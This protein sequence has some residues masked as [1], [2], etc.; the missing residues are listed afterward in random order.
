MDDD[1][2]EEWYLRQEWCLDLLEK[3]DTKEEEEE[4]D[5]VEG[6]CCDEPGIVYE[7]LQKVAWYNNSPTFPSHTP[8][9]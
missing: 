8:Y 6:E 3:V 7:L 2:D 9:F 5:E 1:R 4:E